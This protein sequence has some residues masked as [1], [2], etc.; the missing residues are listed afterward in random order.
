MDKEDDFGNI[1]YKLKLANPTLER[2]EHLT[3]QMKFRLEV[4]N[5]HISCDFI[6]TLFENRKGMVKHSIILELKIQEIL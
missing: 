4:K 1:E 3:T 6:N 2:V 5:K